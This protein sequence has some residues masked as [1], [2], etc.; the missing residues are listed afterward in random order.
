MLWKKKLTKA[1]SVDS[2]YTPQVPPKPPQIIFEGPST[3]GICDDTFIILDI[4]RSFGFGNRQPSYF[5]RIFETSTGETWDLTKEEEGGPFAS[6]NTSNAY[7]SPITAWYGATSKA[8][9]EKAPFPIL[10]VSGPSVVTSPRDKL[11][12]IRISSSLHF[13]YSCLQLGGKERSA[14]F[15]YVWDVSSTALKDEKVGYLK[16]RNDDG[17]G[18]DELSMDI[19]TML[20]PGMLYEF[21]LYSYL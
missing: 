14:S 7:I 18:V 15:Q 4:T 8:N 19:A 3:I 1:I 13:D 9:K 2:I 21:Q 11:S 16:E 12:N 6:I 20:Q 5:W 17:Y 10:S